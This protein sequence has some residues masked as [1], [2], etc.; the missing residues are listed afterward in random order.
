MN[1][2]QQKVGTYSTNTHQYLDS[3]IITVLCKD[4][5]DAMIAK[6][7]FTAYPKSEII[8]NHYPDIFNEI[9]EILHTYSGPP[10]AVMVKHSGQCSFAF[11]VNNFSKLTN[12][13]SVALK[14]GNLRNLFSRKRSL[15]SS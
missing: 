5:F 13:F 6:I 14:L 15:T 8:Y 10:R 1:T 2:W 4:I 7:G 9:H 3:Y 12:F 11:S